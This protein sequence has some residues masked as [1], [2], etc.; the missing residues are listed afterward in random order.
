LD[1]LELTADDAIACLRV[2]AD[3]DALEIDHR[4][5]QHGDDDVDLIGREIQLCLRFCQDV[6]VALVPVHGSD[7]PEILEQLSSIE[8]IT[9][10]SSHHHAQ[11]A[12]STDR[13]D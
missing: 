4:S 3:L 12:P 9:A 8:I 5:T 2:A 6:G 10:F 11:S 13:F 1:D 7:E